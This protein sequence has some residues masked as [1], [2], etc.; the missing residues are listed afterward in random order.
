L[1]L[2]QEVRESDA[3]AVTAAAIIAPPAAFA[4][5]PK[6]ES[7]KLRDSC[8]K[9]S[10]DATFGAGICQRAGGSVS[11][12]EFNSELNPK[13]FR[14]NAWW[15]NASGRRLGTTKIKVGDALRI[16]NEGGEA[17]VHGG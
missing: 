1:A 6:V 14:H 7:V 12:H 9:A 2:G 13:D 15:I 17:H 10:F 8:G 16:T 11:V 5:G 3:G 4:D